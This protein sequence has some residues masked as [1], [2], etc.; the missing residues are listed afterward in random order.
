MSN[1]ED[2]LK[3]KVELEQQISIAHEEYTNLQPLFTEE[4]RKKKDSLT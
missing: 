4:N 1:V 3:R 2:I